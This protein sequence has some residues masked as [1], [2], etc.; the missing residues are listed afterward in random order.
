MRE[1]SIEITLKGKPDDETA[2]LLVRILGKLVA[3]QEQLVNTDE[4]IAALVAKVSEQSTVI[5]SAITLLNGLSSQL[6]AA[7]DD[8]AQIQEI[9]DQVAAQSAALA[10]AV[11]ANTPAAPPA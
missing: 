8:P 6:Q 10:G 9:I 5:E 2:A 7:A 1:V 3:I 4:A 11:A